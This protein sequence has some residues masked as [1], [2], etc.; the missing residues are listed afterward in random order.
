[1]ICHFNVN[2]SFMKKYNNV[3][4]FSLFKFMY[5]FELLLDIL[6]HVFILLTTNS[7]IYKANEKYA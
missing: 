5:T 1:M 2:I 3:N 6:C 4:L 7:Q